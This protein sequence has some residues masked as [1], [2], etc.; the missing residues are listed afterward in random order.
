LLAR[1]TPPDRRNIVFSLKQ[2]GVPLGGILTA[3]V[4][5]AIAVNFGKMVGPIAFTSIYLLVDSYTLVFGML[6]LPAA[7]GLACVFAAHHFGSRAELAAA[8][9]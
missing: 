7:I 2:T 1:F 5:P 4:T 9:G 6:A 3:A 8:R